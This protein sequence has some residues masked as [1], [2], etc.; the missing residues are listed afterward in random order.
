MLTANLS[1]NGRLHAIARHYVE[2]GLGGKNFDAIPYHDAVELGARILQGGSEQPLKGKENLG[3][4]W[5]A[6]LPTLVAGV[7]VIATYVK[8]EGTAAAVEFFCHIAQPACTLRIM[9]RFA[10]MQMA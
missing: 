8:E 5:W 9:D 3:N 7:E 4:Q 2:N 10:L 1:K 6:P